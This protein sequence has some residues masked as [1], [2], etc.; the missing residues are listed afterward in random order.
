M[1]GVRMYCGAR[2][3]TVFERKRFR[4]RETPFR[5]EAE[6]EE[7]A[8]EKEEEEEQAEEKEEEEE[9]AAGMDRSDGSMG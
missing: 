7:E 4:T 8:E 2:G 9:E 1:E 5:E 6:E 3:G